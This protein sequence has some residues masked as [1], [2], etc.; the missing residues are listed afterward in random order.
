M[1]REDRKAKKDEKKN[2]AHDARTAAY[3]NLR[4][5]TPPPSKVEKALTG[6]RG[7]HEVEMTR[8]ELTDFV[9]NGGQHK[10]FRQTGSTFMV[11][12][13]D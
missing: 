4:D 13:D 1:S 10:G 11:K 6:R 9:K 5:N 2:A 8:K 12:L 3:R 7:V